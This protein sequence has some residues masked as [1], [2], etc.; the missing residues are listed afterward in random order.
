[1]AFCNAFDEHLATHGPPAVFLPDHEGFYRFD[2]SWTRDAWERS[3][4]GGA[5]CTHWVLVRDRATGFIQ[6]VLAT[7][8]DLLAV[9]PRGDVRSFDSEQAA[10]AARAEFGSPPLSD[11]P[12]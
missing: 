10:V 11:E 4:G 1:M 9:H 7:G 6:M 8:E 12:W 2:A 3:G 5:L